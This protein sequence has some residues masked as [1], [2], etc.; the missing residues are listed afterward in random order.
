MI[1]RI[2]MYNSQVSCTEEMHKPNTV[3][4]ISQG[5]ITGT[6]PMH[7]RWLLFAN[8]ATLKRLVSL[9]LKLSIW[10]FT[11]ELQCQ[12]L[13]PSRSFRD[14]VSLLKDIVPTK[15]CGT[16]S[17]IVVSLQMQLCGCTCEVDW[18]HY[19]DQ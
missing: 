1:D 6:M 5:R 7:Q 11:Q 16:D 14:S 15:T 8:L 19:I 3:S 2:I 10:T 4:Q 18:T 9:C 13:I 17:P 12:M